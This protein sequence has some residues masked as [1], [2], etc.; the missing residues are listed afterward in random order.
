MKL[1]HVISVKSP[2]VY[3]GFPPFFPLNISP[4]ASG[5][6]WNSKGLVA[7]CGSDRSWPPNA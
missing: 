5:Q 4:I 1:Y 7:S 6:A 2:W 3:H